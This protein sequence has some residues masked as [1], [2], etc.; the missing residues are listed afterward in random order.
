MPR[1]VSASHNRRTPPKSAAANVLPSGD[2][3][4][5]RAL[6]PATVAISPVAVSKTG[7][8]PSSVPIASHRPSG[9]HAGLTRFIRAVRNVRQYSNR[10]DVRATRI[11]HALQTATCS[12]S[13]ENV[14]PRGRAFSS[15]RRT[16][17][18]HLVVSSNC[19]SEL[20]R[21]AMKSARGDHARCCPNPL[22]WTVFTN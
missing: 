17:T 18:F 6:A 20:V 11:C 9:D 2:H 15:E 7:G 10:S 3:A 14:T 16:M 12:P 19:N 4:R 22:N 5:Q 13:G 8:P 21:M 1:H